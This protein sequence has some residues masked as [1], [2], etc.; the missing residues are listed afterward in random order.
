MIELGRALSATRTFCGGCVRKRTRCP[1]TTSECMR[2][3]DLGAPIYIYIYIYVYVYV[4]YMYCANTV[5]HA[6]EA[7]KEGPLP[8]GMFCQE[9]LV[10][11]RHDPVRFDVGLVAHPHP[12]G[13]TQG[14][15][16]K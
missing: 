15:P 9:I 3:C 1:V 2:D 6:G 4:I 8:R 16:S 10:L 11:V 12:E 7:F 5:Y 13:I 14:V